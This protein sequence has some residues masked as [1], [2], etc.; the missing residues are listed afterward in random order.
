MELISDFKARIVLILCFSIFYINIH[1]QDSSQ[2]VIKGWTLG[3][4]PTI[5]YDSDLGFQYGGLTNFYYFGDGSTYPEYLHSLYFEISRFTKGSGINRF[6]YD[7]KYLIPGYRITTDLSYLTEQAMSFYGFNGVQSV[8]NP[9][10]IDENSVSYR[11]RL[12]YAH[13]RKIFRFT[14]D[15]QRNF[16]QYFRWIT[17]TGVYD[18]RIGPLDLDRLNH[19]RK[20]QSPLP[21]T[22]SLYDLYVTWN[23]IPAEQKDG[24]IHPFLKGGLVYDTRDN[25]PNPFKGVFT[26]VVITLY[27]KLK[28]QSAETHLKTAIIHRQ[29]FTLIKKHLAF[30]YRVM[31]QN[32]FGEAPFYLQPYLTTT[33]LRGANNEGLGGAKSIRGVLRNRVVGNDMFLSNVEL[34]AKTGNVRLFKQNFYFGLNLFAD[35]GVVTRFIP[36]DK[37]QVRQNLE[38]EGY[39]Y[40]DFF[41]NNNRDQLHMGLGSGLRIVMNENFIIALDYGIAFRKQDGTSGIYIGLNYA[42]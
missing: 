9:D 13:D 29:Y 36:F 11:S 6:F 42:F 35:A 40:S 38:S 1:A 25:E 8:Y 23:V 26:E 7:S 31:Y 14:F 39:V 41:K 10:W 34:R 20:N 22:A 33:F 2:V 27:P 24:G 4:L 21:D 5:T 17:G 32:T 37:D 30:A 18:Y 19:G 12:F 16:Y 28:G 3:A 15:L